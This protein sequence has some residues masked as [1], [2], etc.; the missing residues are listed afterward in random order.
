MLLTG[1][2]LAVSQREVRSQGN[3]GRSRGAV[4]VPVSHSAHIHSFHHNRPSCQ[5]DVYTE[6]MFDKM[7]A[8]QICPIVTGKRSVFGRGKRRVHVGAQER[9]VWAQI[10]EKP[11]DS[12][13]DA[14]ST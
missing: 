9:V 13:G 14:H 5:D 1:V 3:Q 11:P 4:S 8:D 6:F 10:L 2:K 12:V 7:P